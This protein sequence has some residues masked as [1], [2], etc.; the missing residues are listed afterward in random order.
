VCEEYA[1]L[2]VFNRRE[3]L[4]TTGLK[5]RLS[6]AG[7][8]PGEYRLTWFDTQKGEPAAPQP[9][10]IA[11]SGLLEIETPVVAEDIAAW[12]TAKGPK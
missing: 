3:D 12:I 1:V 2:W 6:L 10:T 4:R 5:G 9:V 11:A 7:M 8:R